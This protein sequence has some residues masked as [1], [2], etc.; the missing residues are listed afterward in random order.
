MVAAHRELRRMSK[1]YKNAIEVRKTGSVYRVLSA[2]VPTKHGINASAVLFDE[3]HA[4]PNRDLFDVLTTSVGARRQPLVFL[5]TTA[6]F[7]RESV[8]YEQYAYARQLLDGVIE[9]PSYYAVIYAAG[10]QDDWQ[11]PKIWAKANPSLGQTIG[12]EYLQDEARR[13]A[14]IPARQNAFRRYH[15]NQWVQQHT[16]W[17][18][19]DLWIENGGPAIDP[20]SLKGRTCYGG[21]DLASV[22]DLA[23]WVLVFPNPADLDELQVI[24]RLWCPKA[25]LEDPHNKYR[26]QYQAW[27]EAG[28]LEATPGDAI[29]YDVVRTR[30]LE[31]AERFR[32]VDVAVD[33]LF[34]AHQLSMELIKEGLEVAGMG[35]GFMSMATPMKEFERRLLLH[36]IRHGGHPVL[37]WMADNVAVDQDAA[38]NLKPNKAS[39]QGKIDGIVALVLALDRAMRHQSGGGG[40]VYD[41]RGVRTL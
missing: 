26:A 17:I 39:S 32:L 13:A 37:R 40:S 1:A 2:D 22:S 5:I 7:D 4:Q 34:Q 3:L 27:A 29:D 20:D 21:L 18:S 36:K 35:M 10:E 19:M 28:L 6:G 38:G 15:L 8:C 9:D 23:A 33:R 25:R 30:I 41:K 12:L 16:R 14:R 31:D 11:D 24:C